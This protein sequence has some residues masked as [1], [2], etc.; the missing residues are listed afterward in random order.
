MIYRDTFSKH[1]IAPKTEGTVY[2]QTRLAQPSELESTSQQR[3]LSWSAFLEM[4]HAAH[5]QLGHRAVIPVS[6]TSG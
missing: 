1:P 3:L 6:H 5:K 2:T 4:P